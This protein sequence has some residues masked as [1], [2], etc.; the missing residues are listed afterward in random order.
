MA[1]LLDKDPYYSVPGHEGLR[2]KKAVPGLLESGN[3]DRT[4]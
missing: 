1:G 4:Y 3:E 2:T